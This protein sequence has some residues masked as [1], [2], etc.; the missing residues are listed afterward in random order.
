MIRSGDNMLK[1][2]TVFHQQLCESPHEEEGCLVVGFEIPFEKT[3]TY[4]PQCISLRFWS[5]EPTPEEREELG[6]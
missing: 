4:Y 2:S 3:G 6:W 5:D 1:G